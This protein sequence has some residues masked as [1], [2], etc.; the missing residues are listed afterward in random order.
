MKSENNGF[1]A[2]AGLNKV[3]VEFVPEREL[4]LYIDDVQS[5]YEEFNGRESDNDA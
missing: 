2:A 1:A 4:S 3:P 5:G